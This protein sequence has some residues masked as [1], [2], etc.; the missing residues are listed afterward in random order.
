MN[1]R[2]FTLIELLVVIAIIAIL[3]AILFPVFAQAKTAA[4]KTQSLSNIKNLGTAVQMYIA[5]V[6]DTY[7]MCDS[8]INETHVQWSTAIYPY[9]K[10]GGNSLTGG[11]LVGGRNF[12]NSGIFRSPAN[13][14]PESPDIWSAGQFS[15]GVHHAI[16][17]NNYAWHPSWGVP[18]NPGVSATSIDSP[19]DK[20][21]MLEKG[22]NDS[23]ACCNYSYFHDY[24]GFWVDKVLTVPNDP[25]TL[26]RDGVDV[27]NKNHPLY[28]P[29]YD[30]DCNA[31][32]SWNWECAMHPRY[33][34]T[35]TSPMAFADGH[36]K[37]IKKGGIKWFQNIWIDRRGVNPGYQ[38]SYLNS[39]WGR[40]PIW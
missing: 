15:Y 13:P 8:G 27:Y 12:G 40:P 11:S 31:T 36:A 39:G 17:V 29:R 32:T 25:S 30:T 7:P 16:F 37:A 20:I 6:D 4:K 35:E 23:S 22:V 3:A 24:Q 34:F 5:D 33:R 18:A 28:D 10:N 38:Y 9:V 26:F 2:A 21:I 19:G 1:K 14:R